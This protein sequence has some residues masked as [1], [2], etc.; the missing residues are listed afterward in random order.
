MGV[1]LFQMNFYSEES[2]LLKKI[3]LAKKMCPSDASED[4]DDDC[5]DDALEF[6]QSNEDLSISH[7]STPLLYASS[8]II[9]EPLGYWKVNTPP[10]K[11]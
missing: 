4:A 5:E 9:S 3:E 2:S 11:I 7:I 8:S 1:G 10:P 6:F